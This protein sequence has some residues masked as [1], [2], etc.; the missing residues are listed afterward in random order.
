MKDSFKKIRDV[1]SFNAFGPEIEVLNKIEKAFNEMKAFIIESGFTTFEIL[2]TG[3][4]ETSEI[5]CT[6]PLGA[7][8]KWIERNREL[9]AGLKMRVLVL[10]VKT[11]RLEDTAWKVV[12]EQEK[13][14]ITE[15]RPGS[16]PVY[17]PK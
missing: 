17:L 10:L 14:V 1:I 12:Q 13:I 8:K 6:S 4:N 16:L 15:L 9:I 7:V 11:S 3:R 2:A 5:I